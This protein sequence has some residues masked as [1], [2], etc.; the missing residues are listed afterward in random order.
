MRPF[1]A[2]PRVSFLPALIFSLAT[3]QAVAGDTISVAPH[4]YH[5]DQK[6]RL[7]IV[8]QNLAE[9]NAQ[10][11]AS[12]S[13]LL[14][15]KAY[16][17]VQPTLA[18]HT[19]ESYQAQSAGLTYTVYFSQL[20][21]IHIAARSPIV[22]SP[23]VFAQF[24][25]AE[26]S[27]RYSSANMG[28]EVRGG[29]SQGY[30][31]KS[32]ELSFWADTTGVTSRDMKFLGMRTDNKWNLQA[33]AHEPM[34]IRSKAANELWQE[35]HTIYYKAAEPDAKNGIAISYAEVFVNDEYKGVYALSERIDRKQLKLKKYNNGITGELYKG[36]DWG[37]AVTFD[38]L[39]PFS[40]TNETWGGFEYM[41]PE[42]QVSWSLLYNFVDFVENSS[43]AVFYQT[44]KQRFNLASAVDY[45]I[46]MNLLRA[47]DNTGKNLY[48][49]KYKQG[50]PYYYVPWDLDNVMGLNWIALDPA[51]TG[52]LS[53]GFYDRLLQDCSPGGFRATLTNRW[54][55]L[56]AS[57]I[58]E[59]HIMGLLEANHSYLESNSVYEREQL[60]W[61]DFTKDTTQLTY[62]STWLQGRL[63]YL[64]QTLA[65]PCAILATAATPAANG[66]R[67]YPNPASDYLTIDSG[68]S[69]CTVSIRNLQG[70]EVLLTGLLNGQNKLD[71]SQLSK[72]LYIIKIETTN[73]SSIS[74]LLIN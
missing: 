73:S 38:T 49:A 3:F 52:L 67:F 22:D 8:N 65:Q 70:K 21:V 72:G 41:H 55:Q 18:V 10:G 20:P 31:K 16:S 33:M 15:D 29:S 54:V 43:D 53:N 36:F 51:T 34:R 28:V 71:I 27:G 9:L 35:I 2:R 37:G 4:L 30:P 32:Y 25:M 5:I 62:M 66:I 56:R 11:T 1:S 59:P 58:T 40:N 23:S 60:V 17:L 47:T 39:P 63:S 14:L 19:D 6:Q 24:S 45:Y 26:S 64:D 12:K 44:Y 48:I 7:I 68:G 74:K 46:F 57:I 69:G 50:E 42:E 13:T 61:S